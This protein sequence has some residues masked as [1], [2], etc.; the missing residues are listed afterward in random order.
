VKSKIKL[1]RLIIS[2]AKIKGGKSGEK[3]NKKS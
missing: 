2:I 1:N 3:W